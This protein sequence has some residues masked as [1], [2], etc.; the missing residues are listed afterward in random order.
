MRRYDLH[1]H[2]EDHETFLLMLT[3]GDARPDSAESIER[4]RAC[5]V[6]RDDFEGMQRLAADLQT[7][8][9]ADR[10]LQSDLG[11]RRQ[12]AGSDL[13]APYLRA[14]MAERRERTR[15]WVP[16]AAAAALAVGVGAWVASEALQGDP[17]V[18]E[19]LLGEGE[20]S[21]A[22]QFDQDRTPVV[23]WPAA[24]PAGGRYELS[25]QAVG[26]GRGLDLP[27]ER[28]KEHRWSPSAEQAAALPGDYKV[29]VTVLD[30]QDT[31]LSEGSVR[32]SAER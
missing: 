26:G 11:D 14:R 7:W 8:A 2:D 13:V 21:V 23:V 4:L 28:T 20:L 25:W 9:L 10:D 5:T 6:C 16:L 29:V 24:A 19:T 15:R 17:P 22:V 18:G 27:P 3:C 32:V 1:T 12:V 30:A 31:P